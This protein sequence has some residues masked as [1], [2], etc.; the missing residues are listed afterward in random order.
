M[1]ANYPIRFAAQLRQ[2]LKAFRK[3]RTLTQAQLGDLVGV[4]QARIAEIEAN[5]GLVR[6]EQLMQILSALGVTIILNED[7]SNWQAPA[8]SENAKRTARKTPAARYVLPVDASRG[9]GSGGDV[10][11]RY[12]V[13]LPTGSW[14][15]AASGATPTS[16][17]VPSGAYALTNKT[18]KFGLT[19]VSAEKA[20]SALETARALNPGNDVV[21]TSR[22][23][24]IVRPKKGTW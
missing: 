15:T 21:P 9:V 11:P 10:L 23:N 4:S 6:F 5:P 12:S 13:R 19:R 14:G 17:V 8:P 24:F 3:A 1:A 2:H 16:L 20:T 22:R 18:T 7:L